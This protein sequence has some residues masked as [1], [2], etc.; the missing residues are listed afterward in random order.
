MPHGVLDTS[1]ANVWLGDIPFVHLRCILPPSILKNQY[2]FAQTVQIV[3]QSLDE[4]RLVIDP[5][6]KQILIN[7]QAVRLMPMQLCILAVLAYICAKQL[8]PLKIPSKYVD[9]HEWTDHFLKL[10]RQ[11]IGQRNIPG[12][13]DKWF[14]RFKKTNR[15]DALQETFS[16]QM[17]KLNRVLRNSTVVPLNNLICKIQG[18]TTSKQS[19]YCLKLLPHNIS[20]PD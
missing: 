13:V 2:G 1:T 3:N 4:V 12:S 17:S 9:V 16:Q 20:F 7:E 14:D 19:S 11:A 6:N 5:A 8:E 10:L 15:I 18:S